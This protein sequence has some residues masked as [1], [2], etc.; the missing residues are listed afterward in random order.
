MTDTPD[1]AD[2]KAREIYD[3]LGP[4]GAHWRLYVAQALRDLAAEKDK[5]IERLRANEEKLMLQI[6]RA[7]EIEREACAKVAENHYEFPNEGPE[8]A[9]A[10]RNQP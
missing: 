9:N 7:F 10:I 1:W 3:Q 5:E 8:I 6:E 4:L 2:E